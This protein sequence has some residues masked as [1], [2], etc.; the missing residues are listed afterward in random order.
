MAF[1]CAVGGESLD[2]VVR[3]VVA[4]ATLQPP[5]TAAQLVVLRTAAPWDRCLAEMG[6]VGAA[7]H[8]AE[9]GHP[10]RA[11]PFDAFDD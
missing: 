4:S 7:S 3:E 1:T 10:A 2:F 9:A 8:W 11:L 6:V 5:L